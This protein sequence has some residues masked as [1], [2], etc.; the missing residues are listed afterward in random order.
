METST[1]SNEKRLLVV[2]FRKPW[3]VIVMKNRVNSTELADFFFHQCE[4]SPG[5]VITIQNWRYSGVQENRGQ[6]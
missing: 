4:V 3:M 1:F 6:S 2:N 5:S